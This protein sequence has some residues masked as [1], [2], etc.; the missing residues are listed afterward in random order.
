MLNSFP[1]ENTVLFYRVKALGTREVFIRKTSG[2]VRPFG[3]A[4][5]AVICAVMILVPVTA[6][7]NINWFWGF[8]PGADFVGSMLLALL[9][10]VLLCICYWAITLSMPRSGSDYV[11]FARIGHP[12]LGFAWS[13]VYWYVVLLEAFIVGVTFM[14][15]FGLSSTFLVWGTLYNAPAMVDLATTLSSP[16]GSYI[17]AFVVLSIYSLFA[18]WGHKLG[19]AILYVG[20]VSASVFFILL[21][22]IMF[23]SNPATFAGKWNTLMSSYVT[24]QGVFDAAKSAGWA[25]TPITL[26]ATLGS[27][28]FTFMLMAGTTAGVGTITGEIRTVNRSVPIAILISNLFAV[29]TWSLTA[30]GLTNATGYD[31]MMAMS[32]MWDNGSKYPLPWPPSMPL[33]A[34]I[35]TY[36]NMALTFLLLATY[37]VGSIAVLW[38]FIMAFARYFFAWAFDRLIP[39]KFA[40][41]SS[42]FKTPHW[43]IAATWL[44]AVITAYLYAFTGF[45]NAFA[46]GSTVM[47]V[48]WGILACAIVIFPFTKWKTL[49]D[50]LPTFMRKRVGIPVI[51]WV[52]VVTAIIMFYAAYGVALNPLLTPVTAPLTAEF[53]VG[54]FVLGV[55][56][57][58]LAKWYNNRQGIDISLIFREVPPT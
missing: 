21:W 15:T 4:D 53:S 9:A 41:V 25:V 17:L 44:L 49:L 34:G 56:I 51:S 57:Y 48:L 47:V 8:N 40:D 58:Y 11:W 6:T 50:Q 12:A 16:V 55:V 46:A 45:S 13:L 10:T 28:T 24:Y 2:L 43:A 20:W 35:L 36:P 54:V 37:L 18:I 29:V 42:R 39:T 30:V 26:T 32:W 31:W 22:V 38:A 3:A 14:I 23:T 27:A 33:M 19:K 52:G 7:V 1:I 5:L